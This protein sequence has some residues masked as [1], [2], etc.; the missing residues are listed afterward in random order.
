MLSPFPWVL[1][2]KLYPA[3]LAAILCRFV[4]QTTPTH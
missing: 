1:H 2:S 3:A 4:T